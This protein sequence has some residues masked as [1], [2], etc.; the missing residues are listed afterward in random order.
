[1]RK[2]KLF[3]LIFFFISFIFNISSFAS[4]NVIS[5]LNSIHLKQENSKLTVDTQFVCGNTTTMNAYLP[6]GDTGVWITP[7]NVTAIPIDSPTATITGNAPSI[8]TLYWVVYSTGNNDTTMYLVYFIEN[9]QVDACPDCYRLENSYTANGDFVSSVRTDTTCFLDTNSFYQLN[10]SINYED[11]Q[12]AKQTS[13][14]KFKNPIS[15]NENISEEKQ[16]SVFAIVYSSSIANNYYYTLVCTVTDSFGVCENKDTLLLSIAKQ[17]SGDIGFIEPYCNGEA[18]KIWAKEDTIANPTKWEWQFFDNPTIDSTESGNSIDIDSL[19]EGPHYV[20]W[21]S[22]DCDNL[23]HKISLKT[24]ND[25]GCSSNLNTK[26]IKEP[27][28]VYPKFNNKLATCGYNN[29]ILRIINDTIITCEDTLNYTISSCWQNSTLVEDTVNGIPSFIA[30]IDTGAN[31][32]VDTLYGLSPL[33]TSWIAIEYISLINNGDT[34]QHYCK[35]TISVII[36]DSGY[37]DAIIDDDKMVTDGAAPLS[38]TMYHD[39][40]DAIE[41]K[42]IIRN[43]EDTIIYEVIEENPIYVFPKGKFGIDLI[44]QSKELCY[45]TTT[46]RYIEVDD[47]SYVKIP[48]MF[49][50]N[51]DDL[52]DYFQV[53]AKSLKLFEAFII[54][55]WGEVLYEWTDYSTKEAGWDGKIGGSYATSGVYFYVIKYQGMYDEKITEE[56]GVFQLA[57]EKQ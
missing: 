33:D 57:R 55:R 39:T 26:F 31:C 35:D 29:G 34:I 7:T 20:R 47:E 14:I 2:I 17:P 49:T 6:A 13:N 37:I 40:P 44:V 12:W 5:S 41:Y 53:Y 28:V 19:K 8:D 18:A 16:D 27:V 50:P 48:N 32:S 30:Q 51:G 38:V 4:S 25:W 23:I 54:N 1:M 9:P 56:T 42:W 52:N 24:T 3:I 15:G 11:V 43:E 22:N 36:D 10:P 46:F 21:T 45:D